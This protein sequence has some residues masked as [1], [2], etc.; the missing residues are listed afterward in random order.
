METPQASARPHDPVCGMSVHPEVAAAAGLTAEHAGHSYYFC[1]TGCKL[2]FLDDPK[3]F[4][5]P[6]Y[7]PHM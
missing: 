6:E 2:E 7:L 5:D 1:S 3:R 4:F